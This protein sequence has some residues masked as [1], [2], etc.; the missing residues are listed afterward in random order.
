MEAGEVETDGTS[1]LPPLPVAARRAATAA[2]RAA[3]PRLPQA[4]AAMD[5]GAAVAGAATEA[6]EVET[7]GPS[8]LPPPPAA[9]RRVATVARRAAL[10]Q[11][12]QVI[13]SGLVVGQE[14]PSP[15]A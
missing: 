13:T 3:T 12:A 9:A 4:Q 5:P 8:P 7:D 1:P 6:G 11:A 2:R 10:A 14:A 15:A